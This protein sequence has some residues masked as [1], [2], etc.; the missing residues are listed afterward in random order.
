MVDLRI[1]SGLIMARSQH[2]SGSPLRYAFFAFAVLFL[3]APTAL[4]PDAH[5]DTAG[6]LINVTWMD[7]SWRPGYNFAD[8]DDALRYGY[9]I[10]DKVSEGRNYAQVMGEVRTDF[11]ITD[12][13]HAVYLISQAVDELCPQLLWQ[14]RNSAAH[15]QPP[16]GVIP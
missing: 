6:Y 8:S 3:A 10:C 5:A 1:R 9:G 16:P 2:R 13:F 12:D 11:N 15:Y 14:L 4:V 7:L